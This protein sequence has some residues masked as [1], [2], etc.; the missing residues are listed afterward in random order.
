MKKSV[1]NRGFSLAAA[2]IIVT[3]A[4]TGQ[5]VTKEYNKE[6]PADDNSS[7]ELSNRYGD[8]I[9]K[10]SSET[11]K[12]LIDVKIT[13]RYPNR[14]KAERYLSYLNVEFS[15][16]PG[17]IKVRTVIDNKFSFTGWGGDSRKF[18]IDY[19]V[20][21]PEAMNLTLYNRY[22][23]TDL[24]DLT[25]LVEVDIKYG[26]LTAGKFLRGAEK[27]RNKISLAYGKASVEEAGWL[28]VYLRYSSG[29]TLPK[30][31]ALLLD[32]KYSN[33]TLGTVSSMV[34]ES[35]YDSKFR[36]DNISNLVID[37]GYSN[38]N[39]GSLSKK[40]DLTAGY[41]SFN[42]DRVVRDFES[43]E[44]DTRYASVTLGIDE[45]AKY[46]LDAKISYGG[47]KFNDE[48]FNV[49]RRLIENTST[50]LNGIM[51]SEEP[52]EAFVKIRSSYATIK[53]YR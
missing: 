39:I 44:V 43:L 36:I 23:D 30:C 41:G 28:D 12:V 52:Q 7:L 50:E 16:E 27:P 33:I 13:V 45:S 1:F 17:L 37:Q 47:V 10:S 4:V 46:N 24:D 2:L 22:G 31:Q 34:A 48:N 38:V 11:D 9:V 14:E 40:L 42:S 21:M 26:N 29:F 49:R 18:R 20:S 3:A 32:S 15:E 35:R 25:G 8:V 51:G 19:H 5:E 6:F 53:L